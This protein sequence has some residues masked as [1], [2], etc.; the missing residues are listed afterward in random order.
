MFRPRRRWFSSEARARPMPT[1]NG[2]LMMTKMTVFHTLFQKRGN[3]RVFDGSNS[4]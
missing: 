3:C 2:V 1:S 4:C